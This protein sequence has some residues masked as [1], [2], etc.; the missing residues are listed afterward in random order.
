MIVNGDL[1]ILEGNYL[2]DKSEDKIVKVQEVNED[3]MQA[4][5]SEGNLLDV[6]RDVI[7]IPVSAENLAKFNFIKS[8]A[9]ISSYWLD[10][11]AFTLVSTKNSTYPKA[12]LDIPDSFGNHMNMMVSTIGE[13]QVYLK[14]FAGISTESILSLVA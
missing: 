7:G 1:E 11:A 4:Y 12:F 8:D 14:R 3:L 13:M 6:G 2:Y 10:G 5:D 9:P